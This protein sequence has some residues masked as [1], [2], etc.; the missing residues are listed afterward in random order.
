MEQLHK[1]FSD[2]QIK[3]LFQGYCQGL[4]T[5]IEIQDM[6]SISKSRFF[7][8][9]HEYQQD[10]ETFSLAYH[11]ATPSRLSATV[12]A[13]IEQALLQEKAMVEDPR[14]PISGY[15]YSAQQDRLAKQDILVSLTTIIQRAKRLGCYQ[16]HAKRTV[17]DREVL[18]ASIGALIQHDGSTHCWSPLADEKWVLITSI[19]DFSRMLLFADFFP[20]ESTWAHIQATQTLIQTYGFPLRYYVDSLRV[21]RFVQGRDSYWRKHVLETDDVDTQWSKMM[22]I[23]GV[24]V[25]YALSP[26]AK[27]KVERPYRWLQDRIVRT[28]ALEHIT[29]VQEARPVLK[30]EV[31]RYNNHQVHSTTQQI[32]SIRFEQAR[33]AGNSLFRPF[34]LPK[35]YTS[36]KDVFCLRETRRVNGYRRIS[37]FNHTI[38]VPNVPLYEEVEI[39]LVP[40]IPKQIMEIRIWWNDKMVHSVA[41][42]LQEFSVHF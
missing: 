26:Q 18:T 42:P 30:E 11:R 35:P 29:T 2:E 3:I 6:L 33:A 4:L 10:R 25:I 36:P 13:A 9:L 40:D 24:E 39:H 41:H 1:R 23:L 16:P 31:D 19:D 22:R 38:E 8:L 27:G 21:F 28:C 37:L 34:S 5:R 32:P 15:N 17:H 7:A 20:Q 12:E 14:L